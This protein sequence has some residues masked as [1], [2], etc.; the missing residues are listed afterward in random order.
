MCIRDSFIE[1][2]G[3]APVP[4][5]WPLIKTTSPWPFET[6]A[7]IVPTPDSATSLTWTRAL[8]FEFLRS[9]ISWA[10]SSIEYISWWGGG[11][12]KVT[13]GVECLNLAISA[14]TLKPGSWPPSPG[15]APCEILISISLQLFK[16]SS[17]TPNL[18]EAICFTPVSYTH[19]TLPTKA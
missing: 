7:A 18:A 3:E 9:W 10:R 12:I 2:S 19:L 16:Y 14:L 15:L 11:E 17:V 6:P 4:P 8:G 5:L 13:P 1:D